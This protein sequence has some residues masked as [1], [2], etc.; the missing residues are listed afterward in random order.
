MSTA[1]QLTLPRDQAAFSVLVERHRRELQLHC[2]RMLGSFEESEDLVQETFLRAWRKRASFGSD[3]RLSVRAWLYRV[4]TNVCLDVLRS[5]PRRVV[6]QD[7]AGAGDPTVPPSSPV[8]LPWLQPYPDRLLEAVAPA[9]DE[10]AAAVVAR[11]TIELAFLAAIQHLPPRQRAVLILRD[12]VGWSAKE[13][14]SLLETSVVSAN[15][16][17]QRARATL[18]ERLPERRTE[19]APSPE[20]S[21][22]ERELLRRYVDAHERADIDALAELLREDAILTMPPL[23]TW[24]AGREAILI[25]VQKGFDP[26]FGHLRSVVTGANL[27]P[28]AAHYLRAP[29]DSAHR[30][31]ALDLLRIE[32]RRVAEIGTFVYPELFPAFGLSPT[33]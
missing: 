5:R 18:R 30:P 9:V 8:D 1:A 2:Y 19:W 27:Q 7:V 25:A 12:V 33:L 28:A 15:S 6:P 26:A 17:L 29:G 24:Y 21:E 20:P 14:A 22:E 23:P 10:P 31:L 16:A 4:A 32:G 11:E 3:G 13:A